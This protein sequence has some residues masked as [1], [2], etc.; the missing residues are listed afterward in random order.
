[1][2]KESVD[3]GE[4]AIKCGDITMP[5]PV[6]VPVGDDAALGVGHVCIYIWE[7]NNTYPFS[8]V[9]FHMCF[10]SNAFYRLW[11]HIVNIV[12]SQGSSGS[13]K[14]KLGHHVNVGAQKVSM[15]D[16]DFE[17][18]FTSSWVGSGEQRVKGVEDPVVVSFLSCSY[19]G[20]IMIHHSKI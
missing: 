12:I 13:N 17:R 1:M 3:A 6:Q 14:V 16:D 5:T 18:I 11:Q 19:N 7:K 4:P 8:N 15:G 2:Y 10:A 9:V 20:K